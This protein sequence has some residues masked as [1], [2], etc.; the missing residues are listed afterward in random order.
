M[1]I[2]FNMDWARKD[3]QSAPALR[4][5]LEG[6]EPISQ[7]EQAHNE[8]EAVEYDLSAPNP[9]RDEGLR[10]LNA[11]KDKISRLESESEQIAQQIEWRSPGGKLYE[12]KFMAINGDRSIASAM[13]SSPNANE[14]RQGDVRLQGLD[15]IEADWN[16]E[17][18]KLKA[19]LRSLRG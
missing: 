11:A 16:T 8:L 12:E 3:S 2:S 1:A 9:I 18:A 19:R 14:R 13:M 5:R 15:K 4:Q 10:Q 7:L 6:V 17:L